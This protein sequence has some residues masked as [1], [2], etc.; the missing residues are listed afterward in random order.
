MLHSPW[1]LRL[2]SLLSISPFFHSLISYFRKYIVFITVIS[3][4]LYQILLY[5]WLFLFQNFLVFYC[6]CWFFK[7][8][9]TIS[10]IYFKVIVRLLYLFSLQL[11]YI[12]LLVVECILDLLFLMCFEILDCTL[13]WSGRVFFFDFC[14]LS[15]LFALSSL[16]A[17]QWPPGLI[18]PSVQHKMSFCYLIRVTQA[19]MEIFWLLKMQSENQ[20][21]AWCGSWWPAMFDSMA[22]MDI[23][24]GYIHTAVGCSI[25]NLP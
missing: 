2:F 18:V 17:L 15:S 22:P 1:V 3:N 23:A 20:K 14:L 10:G 19:S 16:A 11:E 7:I 6:G 24:V 12:Y 9:L 5:F 21:R 13:I 8:S 4:F 25:F